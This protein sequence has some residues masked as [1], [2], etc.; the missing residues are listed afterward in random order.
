MFT[1][2]AQYMRHGM[3]YEHVCTSTG[4]KPIGDNG[5]GQQIIFTHFSR[6]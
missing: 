4:D 3:S 5:V 6:H 2:L 1:N